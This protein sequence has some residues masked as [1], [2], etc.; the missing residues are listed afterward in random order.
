[1]LFAKRLEIV[2]TRDTAR[3]APRT[4]KSE[5]YSNYVSLYY[6]LVIMFSIVSAELLKEGVP[7][8][9][10]CAILTAILAFATVGLMFKEI[11]L[12]LSNLKTLLE[13]SFSRL[14]RLAYRA[15]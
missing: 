8:G 3:P 5:S 6:L 10:P 11:G 2:M 4:Q 12:T 14:L 7:E 15:L 1:V 9:I 13:K